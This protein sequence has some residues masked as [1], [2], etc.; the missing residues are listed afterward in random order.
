M[1]EEMMT[2]GALRPAMWD[3]LTP[4]Q[5]LSVDG[6]DTEGVFMVFPNGEVSTALD[7]F[8]DAIDM[9]A[10][11]KMAEQLVFAMIGSGMVSVGPGQIPEGLRDQD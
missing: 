5:Q 7:V 2:P 8:S 9:V 6:A 11:G 4:M 10:K 3:E 1:D